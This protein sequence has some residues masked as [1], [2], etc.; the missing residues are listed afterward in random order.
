MRCHHFSLTDNPGVEHGALPN[1][2]ALLERLVTV[3]GRPR[4][5]CR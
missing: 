1:D 2:P 3:L 5:R 4:T